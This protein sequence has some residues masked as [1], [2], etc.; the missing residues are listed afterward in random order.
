M[1]KKNKS[2]LLPILL[3]RIESE[4]ILNRVAKRIERE[5]PEL[6]I[7]TIHDSVV[8]TVGNELYIQCVMKDEMDKAINLRPNTE[9]EYWNSNEVSLHDNSNNAVA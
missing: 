9:I 8:T 3:Q 4:I 7:F 1:I 2:N 5:R 6:P